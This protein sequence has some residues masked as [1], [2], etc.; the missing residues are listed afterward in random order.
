MINDNNFVLYA[1]HN[2]RAL[3][4]DSE[5]AQGSTDIF[6]NLHSA[7]RNILADARMMNMFENTDVDDADLAKDKLETMNTESVEIDKIAMHKTN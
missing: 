6:K 2:G 1:C 7:L 4:V 3:S 5:L